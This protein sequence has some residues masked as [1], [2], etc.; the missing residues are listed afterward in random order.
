MGPNVRCPGSLRLLV[1]TDHVV[2]ICP[3]SPLGKA[4]E[5]ELVVK[6]PEEEPVVHEAID[7]PI[8]LRFR[9][10]T[11][12]PEVGG[13]VAL[14]AALDR[15]LEQSD[16]AGLANRERDGGDGSQDH[17][18]VRGCCGGPLAWRSLPQC[19]GFRCLR[20]FAG[21]DVAGGAA[22]VEAFAEVGSELGVA[23]AATFGV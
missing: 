14:D 3:G 19:D 20:W 15:A 11:E 4:D 18:C 22:W 7:Q 17:G 21:A 10:V 9:Q 2:K 23:A 1:V 13:T 12:R 8:D 16:Q 5:L 6:I